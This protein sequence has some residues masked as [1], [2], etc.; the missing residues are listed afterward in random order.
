MKLLR[1]DRIQE[2]REKLNRVTEECLFRTE[3]VEMSE[4]LGRILAKPV[5]AEEMVPS[6]RR[7]SVDGYAVRSSNLGGASESIPSFLK[8]T[9]EVSI[10]ECTSLEV[11]DGECVYVPTGGMI[12]EGADAMVMVEYCEAFSENEIAV[13]TSV[14]SGASVVQIGED[15]RPGELLLP[16]GRKLR[17]QDIGALCAIGRT[18]V[19]VFAPWNVTILSTGDELISPDAIPEPGQIRDINTGGLRAQ[20]QQEGMQITACHLVKDVREELVQR[21]EEAKETSDL[22]VI[23]GGSSQGKKDMTADIVQEHTSEGVLTHGLALKPGKP[24]ILGYDKESHTIIAGL[25][26]HPAAAMMVFEQLILWFWRKKTGQRE[27]ITVEGQMAVNLASAPGKRTCQVVTIEEKEPGIRTV[28]PV[29]GKS[30]MITTLTK[31]DGYLIM[32]ENQEGVK[33]GETVQVQLWR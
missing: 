32:E 14:A 3:I 1:V 23:S 7:S 26:G 13:Y 31:A 22:I 8:V 17:P 16:Q 30:G 24:T 33:K 12:P 29:F 27:E 11:S 5:I 9:G 6:F 15:M 19:E 18:K 28:I 2:A 10:G 25:P 20:A 4:A 21:F